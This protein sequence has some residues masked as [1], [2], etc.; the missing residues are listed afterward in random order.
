MNVRKVVVREE[1]LALQF[2]GHV[3]SGEMRAQLRGRRGVVGERGCVRAGVVAEHQ[4]GIAEHNIA[5]RR[6]GR[7]E[8]LVEG[9][10]DAARQAIRE[11]HFGC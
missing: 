1:I 10:S 5:A 9:D 2:V 8:G 3:Y 7:R 11:A 4:E 6:Q